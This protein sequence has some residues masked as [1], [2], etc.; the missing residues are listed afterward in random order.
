MRLAVGLLLAAVAAY[1]LSF[2]FDLVLGAALGIYDSA[3]YIPAVTWTMIG[4]NA[5]L[6]ARWAKMSRW[7]AAPFVAF[8]V[9]ALI[10]AVL[11]THPHNLGVAALLFAGSLVVW[12]LSPAP[13]VTAN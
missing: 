9:L 8:G 5:I 1:S 12:K 11:G 2:A 10:G 4:L 7:L 6:F 3:A 13:V